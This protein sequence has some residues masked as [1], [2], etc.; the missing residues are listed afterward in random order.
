MTA[1]VAAG[2]AIT[3]Y[4]NQVW[5]HAIG[6]MF[7]Y[8][9]QCP[10]TSCTSTNAKTL[11]WFKIDQAGLLSGSV[12]NGSWGSGLMITQNSSWTTTIPKTVPSGAYL[13]RFETIAL[14]SL[15][16]VSIRVLQSEARKLAN[17]ELLKNSNFTLSALRSPSLVEDPSPRPLPSS[18]P[19]LVA[20][21]TLTPA[22][23][24][25]SN[26]HNAENLT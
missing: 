17:L 24:V 21:L 7:T 26:A 18:L 22:V 12:G 13:I 11:Q 5:P 23:S 1:T 3:A 8:L 16:A 9:A 25:H 2:T 15:P 19:S 10:G 4:W 20:T 14:H 6:P